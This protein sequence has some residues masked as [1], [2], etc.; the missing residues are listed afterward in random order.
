MTPHELKVLLHYNFSSIC[1][2]SR[3]SATEEAEKKFLK[4]GIIRKIQSDEE[5][6]TPEGALLTYAMTQYGEAM[7]N[8]GL[9]LFGRVITQDILETIKNSDLKFTFTTKPQ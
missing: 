9:S 1:Y 8:L 5:H 7:F 4:L 3:S 2:P 6:T